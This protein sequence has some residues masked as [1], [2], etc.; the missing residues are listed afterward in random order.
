MEEEGD[1]VL[2]R[3]SVPITLRGT[4]W[5]QGSS[6]QG[7]STGL[8][9]V[10]PTVGSMSRGSR[11]WK[12]RPELVCSGYLTK[13]HRHLFPNSSEGWKSRIKVLVGLVSPEACRLKEKHTT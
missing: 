4:S 2:D 12:H 6:Y 7:A 11:A 1:G 5:S 8:T 9:V 13:C 3:A 10:G